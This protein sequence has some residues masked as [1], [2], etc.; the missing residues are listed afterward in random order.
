[1]LFVDHQDS[2]VH[3]LANYVRQAG[4]VVTT[5]R[6]G[7]DESVLDTLQPS[8]ILLSPG[9]G[10]PRDFGLSKTIALALR[11][12]IPLCGVCLGMQ[13]LVEYY[14]GELGVLPY[15]MHGKPSTVTVHEPRGRLFDGL[16]DSFQVGRYHSLFSIVGK[17][18]AE[19]RITAT[20]ADGVVMGIEHATLP[21]AAVQ[22]H[23]E[24][25]MTNTD[26]GLHMLSNAINKLRY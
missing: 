25:I 4:A 20:T 23:P 15:P 5:L 14:G 16:P 6:N 18:P 13:G 17:H 2:F 11:R 26:V 8:L 21:I 12:R 22:F 19:L 3:T 7:F 10:S 24:S 1:V 9:P